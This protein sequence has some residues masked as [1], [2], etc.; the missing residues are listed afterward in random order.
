MA[1]R[2]GGDI[3]GASQVLAPGPNHSPG[4]RSLSVKLDP[5]APEGFIVHSFAAD[6]PIKCRDHVRDRAGLEAWQPA[7]EGVQRS[8]TAANVGVPKQGKTVVAEYDYLDENGTLLFQVQKFDP[9][10]FRQRCPDGNGD[11]KYFLGD[12]RRVLY[13]L[14]ELAEAV[15]MERPIFVAEGEKAVDALTK[16]GVIATCSPGGAGKWRDEYSA[17][18][19]GAEVVILPDKDE[20]GEQHA[21]SVAASLAGVASRVRVLRLPDLPDKGDPFDWIAAGGTADALWRLV[22]NLGTK[23]PIRVSNQPLLPIQESLGASLVSVCA[24]EIE[25]EPVEWLWPGR[26]ALGKHT[27]AAGEPGASK[28]QLTMHIA[29]IVST[30]GVWPCGEGNSAHGSVIIL[31]AEDGAADTIIPR[32]H[33]AG[34]DLGRVHIVS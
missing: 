29:A 24:S 17:S 19:K 28:S 8:R 6:D 9:K 3:A 16:I 20:P 34:A 5:R 30:A 18:L 27:C 7:R 12:T 23:E 14:P 32:L 15:A 11:W 2:L 1:F 26:L 22:E 31:S 4:D 25:I 13:R 10:G 33:A 21:A